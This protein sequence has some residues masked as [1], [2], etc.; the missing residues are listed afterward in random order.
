MN[1]NY[2]LTYG[3]ATKYRVSSKV[4]KFTLSTLIFITPF[5]DWLYLFTPKIFKTKFFNEDSLFIKRVD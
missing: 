2:C 4:K 1:N 3:K 5:T